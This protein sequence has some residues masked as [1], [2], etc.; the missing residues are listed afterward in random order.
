[1][2][3][4]QIAAKVEREKKLKAVLS[5]C[6]TSRLPDRYTHLPPAFAA[7]LVKRIEA[8]SH[9]PLI[10][11]IQVQIRG[12]PLKTSSAVIAKQDE[13]DKLGTELWNQATRLRSDKHDIRGV[14]NDS[15]A[16]KANVVPFLRAYA[17]LLLDSAGARGK[18]GRKR[19]SCIRLMKV[20]LKAARVCIEGS[21][22]E[23]A[24]KVL[25]LAA[26]Y[27][28]VLSKRAESERDADVEL[29]DGLRV[30]YFAVRMMLAWRQDH[31]SMAEHMFKKCQGVGK[32]PTS[33]ISEQLADLLYEIG[34]AM[35]VKRDYQVATRWLE[36]AYDVLGEQDQDMLSPE[37]GELR[38]S[39]MQSL[40]MLIQLTW[41]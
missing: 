21:E 4:A 29:A 12:L 40:G 27:E 11:E 31:M 41:R 9:V 39:V 22:L 35:L 37:I 26:E 6:R 25:E 33:T 5:E 30:Q 14:P 3:S 13:L 7:T 17:F 10:P 38:L 19:K 15:T 24:T 36:R 1:M 23:V 34:K 2:P 16:D 18:D 32:S 28:E 8:G 20:A